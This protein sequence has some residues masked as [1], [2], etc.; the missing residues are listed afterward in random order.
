MAVMSIGAGILFI[1]LNTYFVG[2]RG[3][4]PKVQ[5]LFRAHS[6][7]RKYIY[8]SAALGLVCVLSLIAGKFFPLTYGD[9]ASE[10]A[11]LKDSLKLWYL[12]WPVILLPGLVALEPRQKTQVLYSWLAAF[13]VLSVIG[14]FQHFTGWPR[15][16]AIP[17]NQL[18]VRFHAT[19][20]L[21]NHLSVASVF[22]F[23][24]FAALDGLKA[25]F[26]LSRD[27]KLD[28][29]F[30]VFLFLVLIGMV[31]LFFTY[32]RTLAAALP[33]GI[34]VWLFLKLPQRGALV[35]AG[36]LLLGL[37]LATQLPSV[38]GRIHDPNFNYGLSTREDL[39]Q[40]NLQFLKERPLLG[41]GWKHNQELSGYY[42]M[43]KHP[44]E[45]VF[46]GHAHNNFIDMLGGTG[47]L[48][49]LSWLIW[50][51]LA[52]VLAFQAFKK[53]APADGS[54]YW[55]FGAGL[56]CGWIVFQLNGLTQVNFWD[57]KVTHQVMWMMTWALA[58]SVDLPKKLNAE[59]SAG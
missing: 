38:Q 32:S 41:V 1:A 3:W 29:G 12:L 48:G 19:L 20:F 7:L 44:G 23:P 35:L 26:D 46:S 25:R 47:I 24:F 10:V 2:T 58:W 59:R 54:Q 21:G 16:Q 4:F 49:A 28:K 11:I 9:R 40:A 17:S 43:Q 42:L 13:G 39:W 36:V 34:L 8:S 50:S 5:E 27:S 52:L 6:G 57:A 18:P 31:T 14:I 53:K 45:S 37:G 30:W 33:V 55:I 15:P 51:G 56:F 22:I